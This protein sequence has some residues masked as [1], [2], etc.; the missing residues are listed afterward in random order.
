MKKGD[1]PTEKTKELRF[2]PVFR[3][4]QAVTLFRLLFGV[5]PVLL[6]RQQLRRGVSER[7]WWLPGR[8]RHVEVMTA[9]R[10]TPTLH[11]LVVTGGWYVPRPRPAAAAG[12]YSYNHAI[13]LC[14]AAIM[15]GHYGSELVLNFMF[16]GF[17]EIRNFKLVTLQ[18][19]HVIRQTVRSSFWNRR[20]YFLS[21]ENG[22]QGKAKPLANINKCR[23]FSFSFFSTLKGILMIGSNRFEEQWTKP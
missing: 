16:L 9:L 13:I 1:R 11:V 15:R 14:R 8:E 6:L 2:W 22:F 18:F 10:A 19:R 7:R 5:S 17:W 12:T 21:K 4:H 3:S 23:S 20:F